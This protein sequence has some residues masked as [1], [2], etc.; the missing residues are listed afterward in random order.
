MNHT[1]HLLD[2]SVFR[3]FRYP[4]T[5]SVSRYVSLCSPIV[6]ITVCLTV[7]PFEIIAF[8]KV[9][10]QMGGIPSLPLDEVAGGVGDVT[11][12]KFRVSLL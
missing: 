8:S 7:S 6:F 2:Q 9:G 3:S 12:G 10:S 5:H 11:D 4:F 1:T